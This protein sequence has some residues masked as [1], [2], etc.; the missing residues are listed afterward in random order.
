MQK[1]AE[2]AQREMLNRAQTSFYWWAR[3]FWKNHKGQKL[4]FKLHRYMEQIYKDESVDI[5]IE[6]AAQLGFSEYALARSFFVAD[7]KNGNV[8]YF[9]PASTQVYDHVQMR[10]D[11][12]I[13]SSQYLKSI[14]G[15][16]LNVEKKADK[17]SLK[18]VR[19]S[20]IMFRGA[21]NPRQVT[22]APL[23]FAV[24]D[25]Y[26][27]FEGV[28]IS[29][30]EKRL[31]HSKLKW[32][33]NVSTPTLE[34]IGVDLEIQK[35]DQMQWWVSCTFC[36]YEQVLSYFENVDE[37]ECI[38]VCS[39][40]HAPMNTEQIQKGQ[41]K[42]KNPEAKRRGYIVTGLLNP[43]VNISALVDKMHSHNEFV[44]QEA[45]NQDL[46]IPYKSAG[47]SITEQQLLACQG[48]YVMPYTRNSTDAFFGGI[49]VGKTSWLTVGKWNADKQK[50]QVV[51]IHELKDLE[52]DLPYYM[53]F[54][55]LRCCVVD[56][57]PETNLIT[58]LVARY[59][60]RLYAAHY[61]YHIINGDEYIK[62]HSEGGAVSI[63]RTAALDEL[64]GLIRSGNIMFPK[65]V[66]YIK[67]FFDHLQNQNR[68]MQSV[69][70]K[71]MYVYVDNGKPDHY[72]H[73]MNYMLVA[74]KNMPADF[75]LSKKS[76]IITPKRVAKD[77]STRG[78][79]LSAFNNRL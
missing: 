14:T 59:V 63:H 69:A 41:W 20:F 75:V 34:G 26:D 65:H 19:N 71:E 16:G 1:I 7:K 37:D 46:G 78:S 42:A 70:G 68:I 8:G 55:D 23:D 21:Q 22:S 25:E 67:G 60:G 48:D 9:F 61:D 11:P 64:F 38:V 56:A 29:M 2:E 74:W 49:D 13:E 47:N 18:R 57:L 24:L 30:I 15:S 43:Y 66:K 27:R 45:Y 54:Y 28:S 3:V 39:K 40:C 76:V 62:W 6:K 52:T 44:V 50:V 79:T 72:A 32:I 51:G 58:K 33:L 53:D 10:V 73:A 5:T 12:V 35:T 17:V 36:K 31:N 77:L 4:D